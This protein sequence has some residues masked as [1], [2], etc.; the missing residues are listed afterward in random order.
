MSDFD[1]SPLLRTVI[2]EYDADFFAYFGNISRTND[3]DIIEE[4]S[5]KE[6][7]KNLI[8]MLTT[9]GG[10]PHAAYRIARCFKRYYN[11]D[12]ED[13]AERGKFFVFVDSLCSSAGT[14]IACGASEL[15]LSEYAELSPIDVQIRKPDEVGERSSGLTPKQALASLDRESKSLFKSHFRQLR[16]DRDLMLTTKTSVNIAANITIGLFS[17]IYAQLEPMRLGELERLL[18]VAVEYGER[19]GT[20]NLKRGSLEKLLA[21]YP[22]HDFVIDRRE[23]RELFKEVKKPSD[24]LEKLGKYLR[25][26]AEDKA[27]SGRPIKGYI[28]PEP[29]HENDDNGDAKHKGETG[30]NKKGK[31][32]RARSRARGS[33]K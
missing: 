22:S 12:V 5:K 32:S 6:R 15:I 29:E 16:F 4:C 14:L 7:R 2:K 8:L 27:D 28:E 30:A 1:Y 25:P 10:D 31:D 19:I 20:R 18:E 23:A 33:G 3:D 9:L 17:P 26:M 21:G 24:S 13:D 11:V